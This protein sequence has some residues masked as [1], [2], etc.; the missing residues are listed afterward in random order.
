M[1]PF[2]PPFLNPSLMLL[3]PSPELPN[4]CTSRFFQF[5]LLLGSIETHLRLWQTPSDAAAATLYSFGHLNEVVLQVPAASYRFPD[6]RHLKAFP[7]L[8]S[9][10]LSRIYVDFPLLLFRALIMKGALLAERPFTYMHIM[11]VR[12]FY[13]TLMFHFMHQ[14]K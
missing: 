4:F 12:I 3:A 10:V 14:D 13:R 7:A 11:P 2:Q 5:S 6:L 8:S 1:N 9:V